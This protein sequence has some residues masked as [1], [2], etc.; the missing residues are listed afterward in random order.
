[1]LCSSYE[2]TFPGNKS[3]S[4]EAEISDHHVSGMD[5]AGSMSGSIITCLLVL[6]SKVLS[7]PGTGGGV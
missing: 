5:T 6:A 2:G 1:M 4:L 3:P 7:S